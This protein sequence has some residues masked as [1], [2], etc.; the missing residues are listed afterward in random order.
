MKMKDVAGLAGVSVATVSNVLT[1][2]K[3]VSDE[4]RNKVM[5]I[6]HEVDYKVDLVAR[7]LKSKLSFNIGVVMPELTKLFFPDLLTGIEDAARKYGYTITYYSSRYNFE[8][9]QDYVRQ[10]ACGWAD[11]LLIDSCCPVDAQKKW[12]KEMNGMKNGGIKIPVV[13]IERELDPSLLASISVD[14]KGLGKDATNRLIELGKRRIVHIAAPLNISLG[15]CR[16]EGYREALEEAGI[17]YDNR[18]LLKGD[19]S[20]GMAYTLMKESLKNNLT[21]DGLFAANDQSAIGALKAILEEGLNVPEDVAIIGFDNCFPGTLV[22]PSISTYNVPKYKMGY[23]AFELLYARMKDPELPV[24]SVLLDANY[25][26]RQS[27]NIRRDG[28]WDLTR[29]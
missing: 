8:R 9:E 15:V 29:W 14:N 1:G 21:F 2:K 19:Y 26:E 10:L 7:S 22:H 17:S 13:S 24:E 12:A 20:S 5:N 16:Y 25:I 11:G 18:Y 3:P 27:T 23:S 28:G 6:I 4:L